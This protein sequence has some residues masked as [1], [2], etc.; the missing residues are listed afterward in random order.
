MELLALIMELLAPSL[1]P[2]KNFEVV[3]VVVDTFLA[4]SKLS[5]NLEKSKFI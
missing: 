3:V 4:I 5:V 2:K 1:A